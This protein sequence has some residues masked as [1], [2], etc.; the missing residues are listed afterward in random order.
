VFLGARHERNEGRTWFVVGLTAAMM[1][2]E[3][4]GGTILGSMALIADGWHMSTHAGALAIA[5]L[6]YRYARRHAQERSARAS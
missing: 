5:A 1:M 2:V 3:I 4:V 6:S